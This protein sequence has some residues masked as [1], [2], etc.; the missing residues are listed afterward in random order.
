MVYTYITRF[1]SGL[2]FASSKPL[3]LLHFS[4][5]PIFGLW[6]RRPSLPIY[7]FGCRAVRKLTKANKGRALLSLKVVYPRDW[8][9]D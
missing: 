7:G 9:W 5:S 6:F 4:I 1:S 3:F 8:V 2:F